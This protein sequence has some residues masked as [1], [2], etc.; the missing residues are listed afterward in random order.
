MIVGS[1]HP[2]LDDMKEVILSKFHEGL[3]EIT[4]DQISN[5]TEQGDVMRESG[6][7]L[8]LWYLAKPSNEQ[9]MQVIRQFGPSLVTNALKSFKPIWDVM[10][11]APAHISRNFIEGFLDP[12]MLI[13]E[14]EETE[15]KEN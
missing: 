7:Q 9:P 5:V 10:G 15:G 12:S 4:T 3:T 8:S 14:D 2:L 11:G 1:F 13:S 6:A